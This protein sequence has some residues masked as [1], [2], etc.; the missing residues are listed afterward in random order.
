[1]FE[2]TIRDLQILSRTDVEIHGSGEYPVGKRIKVQK[3]AKFQND[4]TETIKPARFVE[5][6]AGKHRHWQNP[7]FRAVSNYL[8]KNANL[9]QILKNVGLKISYDI[10][11]VTDRI[12]TGRLKKSMRPRITFR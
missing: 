12:K 6:A 4:G 5:R 1:M 9:E 10:N 8:F 3:V 2:K 11:V 7:L